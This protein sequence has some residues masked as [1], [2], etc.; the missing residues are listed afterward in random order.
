MAV[1]CRDTLSI[2]ARGYTFLPNSLGTYSQKAET[3]FSTLLGESLRPSNPMRQASNVYQHLSGIE[4][5]YGFFAPNVPDNYKLVFEVHYPD[6]RIEYELP[7]VASSGAGL[8]LSTLLD[9]IGDT[10]SDPLREVM[11]KMVAYSVWREPPEATMI[12]AVFGFAL[13]P[14]AAEYQ[15]GTRE[16]Y[17]FLYAYDLRF[18][19]PSDQPEVP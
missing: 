2:V 16:S 18:S 12:R 15:R 14:T 11:V 1:C 8:R 10:R 9:N 3:I 17:E 13:L 6:G 19:S 5:G 4:S 7:H